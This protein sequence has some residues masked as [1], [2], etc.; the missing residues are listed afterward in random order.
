MFER[1]VEL[2]Y[3]NESYK[4]S[5][6]FYMDKKLDKTK[7]HQEFSKNTNTIR[8]LFKTNTTSA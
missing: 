6:Y 4:S 3:L 2:S 5:F 1:K 8:K 7:Y